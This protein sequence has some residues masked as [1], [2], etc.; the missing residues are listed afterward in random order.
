MGPIY[1]A[2]R[3][4]LTYIYRAASILSWRNDR[5]HDPGTENQVSYLCYELHPIIHSLRKQRTN[6]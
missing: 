1:R 6:S 3:D 4:I 2:L 5:I